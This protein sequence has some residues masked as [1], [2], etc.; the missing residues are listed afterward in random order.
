[1]VTK[2]K[3]MYQAHLYVSPVF[4][5]KFSVDTDAGL[6]KSMPGSSWAHCVGFNFFL[7]ANNFYSRHAADIALLGYLTAHVK[8]VRLDKVLAQTQY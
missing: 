6:I 8:L 5:T 3:G 4:P 7:I 1:M 2:L